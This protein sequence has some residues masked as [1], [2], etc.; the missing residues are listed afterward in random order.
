M[1][2][3]IKIN[4]KTDYKRMALYAMQDKVNGFAQAVAPKIDEFFT[5]QG[6]VR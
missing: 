1:K 3:Q 5:T 2:L 6:G 4:G